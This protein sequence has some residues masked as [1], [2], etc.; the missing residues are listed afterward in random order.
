MNNTLLTTLTKGIMKTVG[1]EFKEGQ[2]A[3]K[4]ETLMGEIM[5][6]KWS[7]VLAKPGI[8]Y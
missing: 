4:V 7:T 6:T 1:T 3:T 5:S 2:A 8:T